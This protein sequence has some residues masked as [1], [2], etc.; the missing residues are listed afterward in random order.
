M[1]IR[2]GVKERCQ[3][4]PAEGLGEIERRRLAKSHT[5]EEAT[6]VSC[7]AI[8]PHDV[9]PWTAKLRFASYWSGTDKRMGLYVA[10]D[11]DDVFVIEDLSNG[12]TQVVKCLLL[13]GLIR[14]LLARSIENSKRLGNVFRG[15]IFVPLGG[16]P[17]TLFSFVEEPEVGSVAVVYEC[18][19]QCSTAVINICN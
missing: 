1:E 15:A 3:D 13:P 16:K 14:V 8:V 10:G 7:I 18:H 12:I 17:D 4:M 6:E 19:F 11:G 5:Q 2:N 9:I